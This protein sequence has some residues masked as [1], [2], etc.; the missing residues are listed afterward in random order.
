MAP[1][2]A[3]RLVAQRFVLANTA[4]LASSL[5]PEIRL[6]LAQEAHDLWQQTEEELA[7]SGLAPPF[8]AFA[9]AG[10]QGLAR[11]I[12]DAPELVANRRVIDFASGSGL[13]A[14][15]ASLAGAAHVLAFDVD[16]F[17]EAAIGLNAALNDAWVEARIADVVG[18]PLADADVLLA[19]DVFFDRALAD[20]LTPW[21]DALVR[22][23]TTVLVGD[24]GRA[25]LPAQHGLEALAVHDVPVTLA[26]EDAEVKRTTVWRWRA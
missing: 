11:T 17:C 16:P 12:L 10:G 15:A 22:A 2:H 13:V 6:H 26:L 18:R 5:V 23:G 7:V 24:P 25:Y 1:D 19:G 3:R 20:R 21:F 4:G 14:I 9:W 8:W